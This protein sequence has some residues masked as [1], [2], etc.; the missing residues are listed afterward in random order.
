MGSSLTQLRWRFDPLRR[1]FQ[2]ARLHGAFETHDYIE[3]DYSVLLA[4]H[5]VGI[6]LAGFVTV[7]AYEF[8]EHRVS[9]RYAVRVS[10]NPPA[11]Q[12]P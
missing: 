1:Q 3:Q 2:P 4:R 6:A 8:H 11:R 5:A 9:K 12:F 7:A 10:E